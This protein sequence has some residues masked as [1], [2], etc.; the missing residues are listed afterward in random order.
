MGVAEILCD[1]SPT[2]ASDKKRYEN[3]RSP[4]GNVFLPLRSFPPPKHP[5][6]ARQRTSA[7][8]S[9]HPDTLPAD[10]GGSRT[11]PC[12]RA[13]R[14][15][16]ESTSRAP[17]IE[18]R[19]RFLQHPSYR[20]GV[21]VGRRSAPRKFD[22]NTIPVRHRIGP[23]IRTTSGPTTGSKSLFIIHC[24]RSG[25]SVSARHNFSGECGN[26]LSTTRVCGVT[27]ALLPFAVLF[28]APSFPKA[29]QAGQTGHA[30]RRR[31]A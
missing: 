10:R 11:V 2:A 22:N 18:A 14:L 15:R 3:G 9:L 7:S 25:L 17:P 12:E 30:K 19:I 31:R 23:E 28:M 20:T 8:R 16:P 5:A 1:L 4:I 26:T 27:A 24:A 6:P 21:G 13:C 29:F